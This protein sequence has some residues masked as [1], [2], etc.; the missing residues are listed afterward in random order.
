[1]SVC[2]CVQKQ[3][4]RLPRE[5]LQLSVSAAE[6]RKRTALLHSN[7]PLPIK[8]LVGNQRRSDDSS[9][10][11]GDVAGTH[12]QMNGNCD[13]GD[14]SLHISA[15]S[16]PVRAASTS[17][18]DSVKLTNG[19]DDRGVISDGLES[20][21]RIDE[22][23]EMSE[24]S[25]EASPNEQSLEVSWTQNDT[26][27]GQNSDLVFVAAGHEA[28]RSVQP[29]QR[30][31]KQQKN[32]CAG[33]ETVTGPSVKQLAEADGHGTDNAS[34]L[35]RRR[36]H[37][38]NSFTDTNLAATCYNQCTEEDKRRELHRSTS[39]IDRNHDDRHGTPSSVAV[40]LAT[41]TDADQVEIDYDAV[42]PSTSDSSLVYTDCDIV[43]PPADF[44]R[45]SP[46]H[47]RDA[48]A[49]SASSSAASLNLAAVGPRDAVHSSLGDCSPSRLVEGRNH[50]IRDDALQPRCINGMG[51]GHMLRM[52]LDTHRQ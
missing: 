46:R 3:M 4:Y 11:Q 6:S 45:S 43:P 49:P 21:S 52:L 33:N 16:S 12:S 30:K 38:H 26:N 34:V 14:L 40:G 47:D 13:I 10:E 9:R 37:I 8:L 35:D 22:G 25:L 36:Q 20:T 28:A 51:R 15:E 31:D 23:L 19:N 39:S 29:K 17:R 24:Q 18:N 48:I 27:A 41:A 32:Y 5:F 42:S 7:E 50:R 1:M 44:S 2:V